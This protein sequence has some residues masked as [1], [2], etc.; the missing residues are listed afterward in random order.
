MQVWDLVLSVIAHQNHQ[1]AVVVKSRLFDQRSDTGIQLLSDCHLWNDWLVAV[2]WLPQ[3]EGYRKFSLLVAIPVF[4]S[5]F[6]GAVGRFISFEKLNY[7]V[8]NIFLEIASKRSSS[9]DC[10]KNRA[11]DIV[12]LIFQASRTSNATATGDSTT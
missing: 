11:S 2:K 12:K 9:E 3:M 8:A 1:R 4:L 7:C 6:F 5:A 10:L